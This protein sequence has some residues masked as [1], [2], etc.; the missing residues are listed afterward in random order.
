MAAHILLRDFKIPLRKKNT[1]DIPVDGNVIRVFERLGL[2]PKDSP[3]NKK[4]ELIIYR[5][6]ELCPD[7]PAVFDTSV[8]KIGNEWCRG[9]RR[10]RPECP[11]CYMRDLCPTAQ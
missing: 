4:K 10:R 2:I 11:A 5:A 8:W 3:E 1:I 7:Y 6:R 9:G